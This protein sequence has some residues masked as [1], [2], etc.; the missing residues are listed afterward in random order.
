MENKYLPLG[1]V[2]LLNGGEKTVMIY[3]RMQISVADGQ[4]YDYVACLYPE[5]NIGDAYTYLFNHDQI[6]EVL[7]KGYENDDEIIFKKEV[8]SAVEIETDNND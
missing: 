7:F 6:R 3:G 8:L 5:G 1:S 4:T 2:V